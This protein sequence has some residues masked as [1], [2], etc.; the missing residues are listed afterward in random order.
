M[1]AQSVG[2]EGFDDSGGTPTNLAWAGMIVVV[3]DRRI[4][5]RKSADGGLRTVEQLGGADEAVLLG[6]QDKSLD[7][8][9]VR[10]GSVGAQ[11]LGQYAHVTGLH[12]IAT[13]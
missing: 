1:P 3:A 10:G 5:G 7:G 8:I 11:A 4:A 2:E 9:E 12:R 13:V 6:Y